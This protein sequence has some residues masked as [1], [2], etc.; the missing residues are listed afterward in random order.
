VAE[1]TV[2]VWIS[3]PDT[4]RVLDFITTVFGGE[5]VARVP[6]EEGGIGH[7]EIR[8][9]GTVLLAFDSQPDWPPT[10]ALLR[11]F[12]DDA[13]AAIGRAVAAGASVITPLADAAWGDR[14]G[15]VRDPLGN[16]WWVVQR[17]EEVS[18]DEIASRLQDPK[19]A[20]QMAR[21]QSSLDAEL[22]TGSNNWSSP[23]VL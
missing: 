19:Y 17:V 5:E 23:P 2:Q 8:V 9:G 10:P 22:G 6:T 15:R 21:A 3:T 14:G 20:D 1:N 18:M 7:A 4:G 12:V 16:I 11:V 13:E